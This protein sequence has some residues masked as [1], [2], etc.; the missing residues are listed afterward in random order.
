MSGRCL[1]IIGA[2]FS[3]NALVSAGRT[4][5]TWDELG[6]AIASAIP[7]FRYANDPIE[8]ISTYEDSFGRPRLVDELRRAIYINDAQPGRP[9]RAFCRLPFDVVCTTNMDFLLEEGYRSVG[10]TCQVIVEEEQLSLGTTPRI[11]TVLKLHGDLAHPHRLVLTEEDY[12]G[13]VTRNPLMVVYLT[14]LLITRTPLFIGYS[15]N[16]PDFRQV[17]AVIHDRLGR[18][19]RQA[20]VI[21]FG[22]SAHERARYDRRRV[23][24]I[25]L[26]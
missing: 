18:L 13:F 22:A 12:D 20:Y 16:D 6:E 19:Q 3:R 7:D 24:C 25:D 9:H 4:M 21:T 15:L 23:H 10:G 14:N 17:A 26:A 1:P 8:A 5:P 2:G 11:P